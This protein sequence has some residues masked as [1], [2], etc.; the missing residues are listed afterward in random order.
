M[1]N[2]VAPADMSDIIITGTVFRRYSYAV[3]N[4]NV[5]KKIIDKYYKSETLPPTETVREMLKT[6]SLIYKQINEVNHLLFELDR[7]SLE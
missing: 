4:I 3:N 1:S 7:R 5:N 6:H 2:D